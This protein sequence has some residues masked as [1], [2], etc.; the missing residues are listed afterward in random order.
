MLLNTQ[1]G[2]H[3]L[4]DLEFNFIELPKFNKLEAELKSVA[5]K[6]IFFIKQAMNL[7]HI[8]A[9]ADTPALR[10]A[11]EIAAQHQ[12]TKEEL[13]V[14]EA[15]EIKLEINRNV[16]ETARIEGELKGKNEGKIEGKIEVALNL[17]V[18]MS[19]VEI[20]QVT[21]LNVDVIERLRNSSGK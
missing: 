9:N 18:A 4:T 3:D 10:L 6:W 16:V 20:S 2:Q 21:G 17:L 7:D 1:T 14:Y 15:Q 12:W 13:E 19:D 8:P 11:Y 5:D